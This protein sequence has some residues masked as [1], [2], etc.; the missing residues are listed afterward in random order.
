VVFD[1]IGEHSDVAM[2]YRK[3]AGFV[4]WRLSA[5]PAQRFGLWPR[6]GRIAPG[7]DADVVLFDPS[8]EWRLDREHSYTRGLDPYVGRPFRGRVVRTLVR[9]RT[10]YKEGE[11]VVDAPLGRFV[12]RREETAD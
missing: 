7:S 11:I 8:S 10:V 5:K 6:K 2:D 3:I 1:Q 4:V 12:E 9:G